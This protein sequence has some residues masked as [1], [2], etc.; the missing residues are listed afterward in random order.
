[1]LLPPAAEKS[2]ACLTPDMVSGSD[3]R[4]QK[5]PLGAKLEPTETPGALAACSKAHWPWGPRS[6]DNG[7]L[8]ASSL[9]S[10]PS[11]D[12]GLRRPGLAKC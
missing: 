7:F 10:W 12:S 6:V 11:S 1:M 2:R 4:K 5:G 8:W 3:G 9:G